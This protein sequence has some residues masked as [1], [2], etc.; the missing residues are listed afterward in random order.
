M[1]RTVAQLQQVALHDCMTLYTATENAAH[2]FEYLSN[3]C[4]LEAHILGCKSDYT[5]QS[6]GT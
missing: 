1:P 3:G 5:K 6:N 2:L 4:E